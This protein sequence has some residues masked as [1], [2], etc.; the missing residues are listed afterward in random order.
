[1]VLILT[2]CEKEVIIEG[3]PGPQ[4]PQGEAGNANVRSGTY[5]VAEWEYDEPHYMADIDV[6]FITNDIF[7]SGVILVYVKRTDDSFTQLPLTFY[8]SSDY[9]TTLEVISMIGKVKLQWTDSDLIQPVQPG[10]Y[11]FKIVVIE[12]S[13]LLAQ[14]GVNPNDYESVS[15]AFNLE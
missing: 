8:W 13:E 12:S 2:S 15:R 9:S 11:T 10:S 7:A 3:P 1:M 6:S 14:R 4:G 5:Q